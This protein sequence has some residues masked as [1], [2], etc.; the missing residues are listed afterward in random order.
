[1]AIDQFLFLFKYILA[2]PNPYASFEMSIAN[3]SSV[4]KVNYT[5]TLP[6]T[7]EYFDWDFPD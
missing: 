7:L 6:L 1:M 2:Q 5:Q 3:M 4:I